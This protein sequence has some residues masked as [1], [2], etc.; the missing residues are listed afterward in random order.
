MR[1]DTVSNIS[2]ISALSRP[3]G[4]PRNNLH[5]DL[6]RSFM[7]SEVSGNSNQGIVIRETDT[8]SSGGT[9]EDASYDMYMSEDNQPAK[10]PEQIE[11]VKVQDIPAKEQEAANSRNKG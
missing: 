2:Y 10:K 11:N 6:S 9:E 3:Y 5:G 4:Q 1:A 7:C 8:E